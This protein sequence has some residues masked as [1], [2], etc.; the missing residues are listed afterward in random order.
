MNTENCH[1]F[2]VSAFGVTV[3]V[4][5]LVDRWFVDQLTSTRIFWRVIESLSTFLILS[6][7]AQ[8]IE[9]EPDQINLMETPT[10]TSRTGQAIFDAMMYVLLIVA[11]LILLGDIVTLMDEPRMTSISKNASRTNDNYYVVFHE[12]IT[13]ANLTEFIEKNKMQM[14]T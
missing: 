9:R 1:K 8:L 5:L 2:L 7:L 11:F 4:T 14:R 10:H 12:D 6:V 13:I 3:V